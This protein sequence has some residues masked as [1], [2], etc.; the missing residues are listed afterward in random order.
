MKELFPLQTFHQDAVLKRLSE[1]Y[2]NEK[3]LDSKI[4]DV[5]AFDG[6]V[7]MSYEPPSYVIKKEDLPTKTGIYKIYYEQTGGERRYEGIL[8]VEHVSTPILDFVGIFQNRFF[9]KQSQNYNS[10][11]TFVTSG[12]LDI[13]PNPALAGTESALTGLQVG[14]DKYKV[15]GGT[16]LYKHTIAVEN[17]GLFAYISPSATE[18][19]FDN[20]LSFWIVG[21]GGSSLPSN[22]YAFKL[23]TIMEAERMIQIT[24][25]KNDFSG[26]NYYK[27]AVSSVTD[28]IEEL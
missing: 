24:S 8:I 26:F 20:V 7:Q 27:K 10:D 4:D 2:E 23:E 13:L 5:I 3:D 19:D 28:T 9:S 17:G 21:I 22:A 25:I 16:K 14:S 15:S 6:E 11:Y 18:K 1:L 12:Y